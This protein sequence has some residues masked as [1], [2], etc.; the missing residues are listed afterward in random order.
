MKLNLGCG[1]NHLD[2]YV[3]VD[4]YGDPNVT[5]DLEVFPWPW[6]DN[7]VDSIMLIHVLEHLGESTDTFINIMK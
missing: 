3:N 4:K 7:S 2:G 1:Q 5:C 6:E